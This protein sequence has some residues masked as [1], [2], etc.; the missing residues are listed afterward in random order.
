MARVWWWA[1]TKTGGIHLLKL[2]NLSF[3]PPVLTAWR[4]DHSDGFGCPF[5]G[6]WSQVSAS[7]LGNELPCPNCSKA[8][9]LNPFTIDADRRP[10]AK[11]WPR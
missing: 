6:V 5:C 4:D 2:E 1:L 3:A 10:I 11:A 8:V 9:K 7:H